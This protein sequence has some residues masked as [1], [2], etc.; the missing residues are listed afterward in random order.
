MRQPKFKEGDLVRFVNPLTGKPLAGIG[1]VKHVGRQGET[2]RFYR[3]VAD[4]TSIDLGWFG[5]AELRPAIE[6]KE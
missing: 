5:P 4:D 6:E 1:R 2:H 3:I